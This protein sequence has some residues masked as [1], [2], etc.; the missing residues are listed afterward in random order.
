VAGTLPR[1]TLGKARRSIMRLRFE[2][3]YQPLLPRRAFFR[4]VAGYAAATLVLVLI[5]LAIGM[6]G[7]HA[8]ERLSWIDAYL[9][10]AMILGGM[11]PVAEIHTTA[12]KLF[13]G[14][15]A[16]LSGFV[17]LVA[18]GLLVTPV[19]HRLLHHFHLEQESSRRR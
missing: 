11:G 15:Y 7:Y 5:G 16:I 10:A 4:R 19:L 17:L 8:L 18:A 3:Q 9:N 14:T 2:R 12:G 13:A 1:E 6:I